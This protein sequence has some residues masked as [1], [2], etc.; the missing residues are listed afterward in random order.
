MEDKPQDAEI[1]DLEPEP[2]P[3][4]P[5]SAE[6]ELAR[7]TTAIV[8]HIGNRF[9]EADYEKIET[10]LMR[11][12]F[13]ALSHEQR[14]YILYKK[15]EAMGISIWLQPYTWG[16]IEGKLTPVPLKGLFQQLRENR[17]LVI[18]KI[19]EEFKDAAGI[20][21]VRCYGHV[22]QRQDMGI[23]IVGV[24]GLTGD[25]LANAMMKAHCVP[26]SSEIL[27][28]TGFKFHDQLRIGED[29]LA[30]DVEAGVCRWTTL[31]EVTRFE[32]QPLLRVYS[33]KGRWEMLCTPGHSWAISRETTR[34]LVPIEDVRTSHKLILAAEEAST[35]DEGSLLSASEAALLAWIVSDGTI[36]Q[37]QYKLKGSSGRGGRPAL[38]SSIMR[39]G[40]AQ[41]KEEN[42]N[43][44]RSL[45]VAVA[46]SYTEI[47]SA[48]RTRTFPTGNVSETLA[49]HWW[50]LPI[51]AAREL[52]DKASYKTTADL[53]RIACAL[54]PTAR[55]AML[56]AFMRAEG[57]ARGVMANTDEKIMETFQILATL[58]GFA[59]GKFNTRLTGPYKPLHTQRIRKRRMLSGNFLCVEPAPSAAV[60]CP[61]TK[62]GTWIMRQGG[63]I[64]ITGNTKAKNRLTGSLC[65]GDSGVDDTEMSSIPGASMGDEKP[66]GIRQ[67]TPGTGGQRNTTTLQ[68][69]PR[70]F[71]PAGPP[72]AGV[73]SG[74][75]EPP[76]LVRPMPPP[77]PEPPPEGTCLCGNGPF[78]PDCLV[79][80]APL[81]DAN[82]RAR[83]STPPPVSAPPTPA[84]I[85][86]GS[87]VP[88]PSQPQ[89]P[90]KPL[91]K[92]T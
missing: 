62:F 21:I 12:D 58:Q 22:G 79:H 69:V 78:N 86:V 81:T 7:P 35:S 63:R 70:E 68:A 30:Y 56:A 91:L 13:G 11:S 64:A 61:T 28:R 90:K 82:A 46:G 1:V 20:Y 75:G 27:T 77:S 17:G 16:T 25:P 74:G 73:V 10:A 51:K 6:V 14:A 84:P 55:G 38:A 54:G 60:W 66:V 18:D 37:R 72:G 31:Q 65:G 19:E 24:K 49:Q 44:I 76:S 85:K 15:C 53:P 89:P 36:M 50:Y 41:S 5:S 45:A 42:F 4:A 29:V 3:G 71:T 88:Q 48:P 87:S 23:G 43:E 59:V 47:V 80:N 57:T 2:A 34:A 39:V 9:T 26:L 32:D 52:L 92:A 33:E 40:V 67:I 83:T 8:T